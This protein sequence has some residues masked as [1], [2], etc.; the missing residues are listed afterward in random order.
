MGEVTSSLGMA[1]IAGIPLPLSALRRGIYITV[2]AV[3]GFDRLLSGMLLNGL[4]GI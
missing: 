2:H 4:A 1:S 3:C